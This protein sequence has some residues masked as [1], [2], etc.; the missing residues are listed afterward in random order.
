MAPTLLVAA[1]F[2]SVSAAV[3]AYVGWRL[4]R[5]E[6][7]ETAKPAARSFTVWWYG[8]ALV[9]ALGA[10]GNLAGTLGATSLPLFVALLYASLALLCVALW[11]L[12]YF[13]LY[14]FTGRRGL[15]APLAVFYAAYFA[16]LVAVVTQAAPNAV[17]VDRW[18]THVVYARPFEGL[19]TN[20]LL[21]LLILPQLAGALAYFT[22]VFRLRE[23]TLRYRVALV[24]SSIIVWFMSAYL[25]ALAGLAS[26]DWWQVASRLLGL[27]AAT[28]ILLAYQPPGWIRRRFG[29][30]ALADDARGAPPAASLQGRRRWR[31][32]PG[33]RRVRAPE[34]T[35]WK[36]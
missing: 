13:L 10:A 36:A 11:G 24:S 20:V 28:A 32:T 23:P 19:V 7:E 2:A 8:L 31:G 25:G 29:I 9:T 1:G 22:L 26:Q 6:V 34:R 27:G 14:L 16:L 18:S 21:S 33:A 17:V 35:S 30:R 15:V 3:F 12:L 4:G 5:R